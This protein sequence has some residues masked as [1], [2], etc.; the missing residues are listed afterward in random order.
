MLKYKQ[1]KNREETATKSILLLIFF[2]ISI[3]TLTGCKTEYS[4]TPS[5]PAVPTA[6]DNVDNTYISPFKKVTSPVHFVYMVENPLVTDTVMK[7]LKDGFGE[8]YTQVRG[9]KNKELQKSINDTIKAFHDSNKETEIPP[10]RGIRKV[11]TS[12]YTLQEHYINTTSSFNFN[13]ILSLYSNCSFTFSNGNIND[14]IYTD[15]T[16]T[17]T[18]DLNTGRV[19]QFEDLFADDVDYEKIIN[20]YIRKYID[21]EFAYDENREWFTTTELVAPFKG[22]GKNPKFVLS[23]NTLNL[24]LDSETP[25]FN[26][27]F[28]TQY[29]HIPYLELKD[30]LAIKDRFDNKVESLYLAEDPPN[31]IMINSYNRY[32][33]GNSYNEE[34]DGITYFTTYNYP[35]ETP[36]NVVDE[37]MSLLEL[38]E[39]PPENATTIYKEG[40][41]WFSGDYISASI[42]RNISYNYD[43]FENGNIFRVYDSNGNEMELGEI[44]VEGYNYK[45]I[46]TSIIEDMLSSVPKGQEYSLENLYES[47]TFQINGPALF[48]TTDSIAMSDTEFYP[49]TFVLSFNEIGIEN[50]KIMD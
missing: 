37:F 26:T 23:Y 46:I 19:I 10:Y 3:V 27:Q 50:L 41:L 6:T 35:P 8:S 30:I 22:I 34:K 45:N 44:F 5:S 29:L 2:F 39:N 24:V 17:L 48:F 9:L 42:R 21:K 40:S 12:D 7:D 36:Q 1:T 32:V 16:E 4:E 11:L 13:N 31:I 14:D 15:F 33:T 28:S 25:E 43:R 49:L 47:L 38:N 20:D 18:I